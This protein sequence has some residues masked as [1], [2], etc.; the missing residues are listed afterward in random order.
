MGIRLATQRDVPDLAA[1]LAR[2]FAEAPFY[3]YLTGT[4]PERN[5]RMRDG[6]S[7]LLRHASDRLSTTYTTDDLAGVAVW[8]PPGYGG[9]SFIGSLRLLPSVARLVGGMRRLRG[10]SRAVAEL[11]RHRH[12][13]APNPHFYLSALGVDPGRQREGIGTALLRP[14]LERADDQKM[15]A[16]LET[17]TAVNVLMYERVGFGVVEELTLPGTDVHGWLMLRRPR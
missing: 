2:A 10:V 17:A 12:R 4:A 16:Y 15:P 11:E 1:V 9:A 6:W 7:G 14:V 8:H 3:S 5:Q 13:H